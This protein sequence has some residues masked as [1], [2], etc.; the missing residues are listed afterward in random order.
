[1]AADPGGA[2][3]G[4]GAGSRG[5]QGDRGDDASP[6]ARGRGV[7][8]PEVRDSQQDTALE[9]R[10]DRPVCGAFRRRSA[11]MDADFRPKARWR[12]TGYR[13]VSTDLQPNLYPETTMRFVPTLRFLSLP[14]VALGTASHTGVQRRGPHRTGSDAVV[15]RYKRSVVGR[16]SQSPY[17]LQC[18]GHLGE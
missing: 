9:R 7:G 5:D 10:C 17:H 1:M 11:G 16:P 18:G 2:A 15:R 13:T 14:M 8:D 4:A 3:G 12:S 6:Q